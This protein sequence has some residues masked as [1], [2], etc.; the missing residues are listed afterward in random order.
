[1]EKLPR[2]AWIGG[3]VLAFVLAVIVMVPPT[4]PIGGPKI[5][6]NAHHGLADLPKPVP[7]P[8]VQPIAAQLAPEQPQTPP[9]GYSGEAARIASEGDDERP[10]RDAEPTPQQP[11]YAMR[12][13]EPVPAS[14]AEDRAFRAGY[15]WAQR[16][17]VDDPRACGMIGDGPGID[18]CVAYARE[19][20]NRRYR[21][22]EGDGSPW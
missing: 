13:A 2:Q 20:R 3:G 14:D 12:D 16:Q 6:P 5:D 4:K 22:E 15:R 11:R 17:D 21:D 9:E 18:G 8:V 7:Q 19:A 10:W 1:M